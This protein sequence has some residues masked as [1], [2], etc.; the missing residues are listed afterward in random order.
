M[1][2]VFSING[3]FGENYSWVGD[4]GVE[5]TMRFDQTIHIVS[6]MMGVSL[7]INEILD[8]TPQCYQCDDTRLVT[9]MV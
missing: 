2:N 9:H 7:V 1:Y 4:N 5:Y 6:K 8:D 3:L